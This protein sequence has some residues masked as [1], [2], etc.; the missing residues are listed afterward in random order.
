MNKCFFL[1]G[2][3]ADSWFEEFDKT[4]R[5]E[6]NLEIEEKRKT[7]SGKTKIMTNVLTFEAWDTAAVAIKDNIMEGDQMLV[8]A[9]ARWEESI[10][11]TFFRVTN[12][13]IFPSDN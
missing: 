11:Q 10:D 6:F 8:E 7:K 2:V 3:L 13:K 1:G 5:I 9:S 12:F 4:C